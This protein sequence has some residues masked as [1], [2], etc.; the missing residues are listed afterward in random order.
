MGSTLVMFSVLCP[1]SNA[2]MGECESL[3]DCFTHI[4]YT[5][6]NLTYQKV[7]NYINFGISSCTDMSFLCFLSDIS[8]KAECGVTTVSFLPLFLVKTHF[9]RWKPTY[10]TSGDK[11]HAFLYIGGFC[12]VADKISQNASFVLPHGLKR[13]S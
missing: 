13:I 7:N 5:L 2:G 11:Q 3:E 4:V 10:V 6:A 9:F 8:W 12:D 1:G